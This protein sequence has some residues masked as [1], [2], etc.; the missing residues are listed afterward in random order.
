MTWSRPT[1]FQALLA[2]AGSVCL[3]SCSGPVAPPSTASVGSAATV[4]YL[5][6]YEGI[7]GYAV[8]SSN[9]PVGAL[10]YPPPYYYG[11]VATDSSGLIYVAMDCCGG[12]PEIRIYSP[13][14]LG[15][16]ETAP[17]QTIRTH[18]NVV[19]ALAVVNGLVYVADTQPNGM[20]AVYVY[21]STV[22]GN[23]E[24]RNSDPVRT[25]ILT[26]FQL[27]EDIAADAAEN[28]YVAGWDHN[29]TKIIAVYPPGTSG[30]DPAP[31]RTIVFLNSEVYGVAVDAAGDIF[32]SSCQSC[33][34]A[35]MELDIE[36]F[37]PDANGVATPV[38]TILLPQMTSP[39]VVGGPVRL[40]GA[41]DIFVAACI[42]PN[43][44]PVC[45]TIIFGFRPTD[46]GNDTPFVQV[47][48]PTYSGSFAVN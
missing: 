35:S 7:Y 29:G 1:V 38:R 33:S 12:A 42:L 22:R 4:I 28:I 34:S 16:G 32:A 11:N 41:G 5:V 40:D 6:G 47:A 26:N 15:E 2:L 19:E 43:N 14:S 30:S 21:S 17:E 9:V 23:S 3:G 39:F 25:L 46:A 37:A 8:Q 27:I 24:K 20:Q 45:N 31:N 36:E 48:P 10:T 18:F 44:S 13:E